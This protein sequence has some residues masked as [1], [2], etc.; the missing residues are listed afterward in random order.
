MRA[1]AVVQARYGATRLKGKVLA[2]I[3][4]LPL[5]AHVL[6][7]VKAS[8]VDK[9]VLACPDTD[10]NNPVAAIGIAE[11][12][13]V[14]RG[15]E[16]DV[17]GRVWWAAQLYQDHDPIVRITAD[18][19]FK[20]PA[21][22][23][24]VL[25]VWVTERLEGREWEYMVLGGSSWPLGC[26]VEVFTRK[27]LAFAFRNASDPRDREHV[28]PFIER[29]YEGQSLVVTHPAYPHTPPGYSIAKRWTI[30]TQADL[31]YARMVYDKLYDAN[32]Y[33]GYS[34]IVEAQ[35]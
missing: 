24:G 23:D 17:L 7:R 5:L 27:A 15:D 20:D 9:V 13:F 19:P 30:D 8:Q 14:Y 29:H 28:T 4:G 16:D 18:D 35:L 25:S 33:F 34:E 6:R 12:V 2:D 22:I 21:L 26:V 10:E 3:H 32:P 1:L 31:D 11:D